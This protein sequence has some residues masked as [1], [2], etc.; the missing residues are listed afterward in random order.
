MS[1]G[2]HRPSGGRHHQHQYVGPYDVGPSPKQIALATERLRTWLDAERPGYF[3]FGTAVA[4]A[5]DGPVAQKA[6]GNLIRRGLVIKKNRMYWTV[7]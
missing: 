6:L 4:V 5:G 7:R 1:I 3:H 2:H